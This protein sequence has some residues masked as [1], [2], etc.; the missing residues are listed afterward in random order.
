MEVNESPDEDLLQAVGNHMAI[1]RFKS[2]PIKENS[3]L[4]RNVACLSK[5]T[6]LNLGSFHNNSIILLADNCQK[7]KT[8]DLDYYVNMTDQM[9]ERIFTNFGISKAIDRKRFR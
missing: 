5:L 7:L 8:L 9:A 1:R 6:H 3:V 4:E 2:M